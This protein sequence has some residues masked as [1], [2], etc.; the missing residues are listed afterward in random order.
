MLPETLVLSV[1]LSG[2]TLGGV[3]VST[4]PFPFTVEA[5]HGCLIEYPLDADDPMA[6]GYQC[7]GPDWG[8]TDPPCILGQDAT[9]DRRSQNSRH[10][11]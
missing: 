7:L 6:P 11:R 9:V 1:E 10:A 5:C 4:P 8:Y 2:K 3:P